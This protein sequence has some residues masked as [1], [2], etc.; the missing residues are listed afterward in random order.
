MF[1]IQRTSIDQISFRQYLVFKRNTHVTSSV[2]SIMKQCLMTSQILKSVDSNKSQ[3][4]KYIE[5]NE[6][7]FFTHQGL[8]YCKK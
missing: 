8:L 3:K 4:S 7:I 2:T 1:V 6:N 5:N